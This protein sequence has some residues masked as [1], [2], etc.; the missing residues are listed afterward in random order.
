MSMNAC[1]RRAPAAARSS[2]SVVRAE[3]AEHQQAFGREQGASIRGTPQRIVQPIMRHVRP[4]QADAILQPRGKSASDRRTVDM[5]QPAQ[6]AARK[7]TAR[8]SMASAKS[9]AR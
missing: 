9:G 5:G 6:Q 4:H 2:F 1:T 3:R 7:T 8:G